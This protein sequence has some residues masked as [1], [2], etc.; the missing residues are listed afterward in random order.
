MQTANIPLEEVA[1]VFGDKVMVKLDD[2]AKVFKEVEQDNLEMI[3]HEQTRTE[4]TTIEHIDK[5]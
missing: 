4:K 2:S 5:V 1:A 3:H